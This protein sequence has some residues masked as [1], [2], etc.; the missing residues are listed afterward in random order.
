MVLGPAPWPRTSALG[1]STLRYSAASSKRLP[2]SKAMVSVSRAGL[3]RISL[4]QGLERGSAEDI[5]F[6]IAQGACFARQHHRHAVTDG[7]GEAG[8]AADQFLS[9]AVIAQGGLGERAD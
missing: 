1:D 3:R 2:S 6:F 9:V 5:A 7:I 8:S 4:G